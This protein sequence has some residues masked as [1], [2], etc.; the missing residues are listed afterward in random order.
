MPVGECLAIALSITNTLDTIH[1]CGIIHCDIN[2]RNIV[3]NLETGYIDVIEL[4]FLLGEISI[5]HFAMIATYR[6]D[7]VGA[8][9][10]LQ[11]ARTKSTAM[12][13]EPAPLL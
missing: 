6:D 10:P 3:Y 12:V 4:V 1:H 5:A 11:S 7:E 8:E 2:S 13:S 9:P